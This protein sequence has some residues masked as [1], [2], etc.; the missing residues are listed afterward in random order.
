MLASSKIAKQW[1]V[2][3]CISR[4]QAHLQQGKEKVTFSSQLLKDLYCLTFALKRCPL[5]HRYEMI[6]HF[7][8]DVVLC[9]CEYSDF[10]V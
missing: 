10:T 4:M 3:D 7:P 6:Y 8:Q 5:V 9:C 2:C 1:I